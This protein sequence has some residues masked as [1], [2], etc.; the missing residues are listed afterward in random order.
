M[1]VNVTT[2][3]NTYTGDGSTTAYSVTFPILDK[4]HL[5]VVI[6]DAD[7][8]NAVTKILDTDYTVSGTG[9]TVS[10][11]DY[12]SSTI[13]FSVAPTSGYIINITRD[14]PFTQETDYQE[15]DN[16]PAET[17]ER[18]LDKLTMITQQLSQTIEDL[19]LAGGSGGGSISDGDKGDITVSASG[20]T[21]TIDSGAVTY[22]KIQDISSTD[23]V[24]GR[25]SSGSGDI[26][27]ITFTDFAQSLA[28]DTS[29]SAARNTLGLGTISIQDSNNVSITAGSISGVSINTLAADLPV[30]DGGTGASSASDARTNLGLAIGTDV[31]AYDADLSAIAG[32]VSAADKVPYYT[33][34]GTAALA[35]LTSTARTLLDDNSTSAMRTTL[36][37][38]IGTDVQAYDA[39]LA[40]LATNYTSAS[41]S[42]AASL[43]MFEDTDNGTNK[44]T[45]AAPA[46][47]SSNYTFTLPN[48]PGTSGYSLITDGS[49]AT[50]WSNVSGGGGGGSPGG[51]DGQ[52]Q[53]NSS[54]SFAADG[55]FVYFASTG[56][57]SLSSGINLGGKGGTTAGSATFL[58][59]SG[60]N[61]ISITAPSTV[62][63]NS[64]LTLPVVTG[65]VLTENST[66]TLTN[67][68]FDTAGSGNSFSINGVAATANTGTGAIARAVSPAFTTPDLG[69]AS[70]T[71]I[72]G[73]TVTGATTTVGSSLGFK[74]GTNNGT[75]T[76]TL[77]AP[78]SISD[79]TVTMP[80]VTS[81]LATLAGTE[82]LTN[83]TLTLPVISTISNT[84]TVT[85]FTSS[86]TVVGR[87]TTDTL[88][89]KT[90][91]SPQLNT[92]TILNATETV[93][94]PT[95]TTGAVTIDLSNGTF[96][97]VVTAQN[98]TITLP[99]AAAG[100]SYT[101]MVQYGGTHTITWAGGSTIKWSGGAAPTATSVNG[102]Y[103]IYVFT[104]H[105]STNT[106]G[107]DG[108]RNY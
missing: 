56:T 37:L 80:S 7:G 58:E 86:D 95:V 4:S 28:D 53:Y 2:N 33:G 51:A 38:T 26:E 21:W 102:K 20:A 18:A 74:E 83:K 66:A 47:I 89:N 78:A 8:E 29:A 44:V 6:T 60:V 90:M 71:S 105:D 35:D 84:G 32:L 42:G 45:L 1:T 81:T 107:T 15:G 69:V 52:V 85:L 48:A 39:D 63:S 22:A 68:T 61:G 93:A 59:Q 103:D 49:G 14:V 43:A 70:V 57:A 9:N 3:K 99:S 96:Q 82:T 73:I 17:H 10:L 72:N 36:G 30:A 11:T 97:K 25:V 5:S 27:E 88:T 24:L 77:Q 76:L 40:N 41:A 65:T 108:G 91:T 54:G 55:E 12:T 67:K 101:I 19:E 79:I 31:Q 16:F 64:T 87:A 98:T 94:T 106:F 13:T 92:P 62:A 50:S 75:N 104:C 100:K 46:S 34:S 23:K